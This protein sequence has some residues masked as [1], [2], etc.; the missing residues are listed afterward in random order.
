MF[1]ATLTP[2]DLKKLKTKQRKAALKA[3]QEKHEKQLQE[4]KEQQQ[5]QQHH[6]NKRPH[7]QQEKEPDAPPADDL[8]PQK[9]A[10]VRNGAHRCLFVSCGVIDQFGGGGG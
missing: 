6:H 10:K 8:Q 9:L 5:Q 2:A 3:E 7:N 4:R 1:I